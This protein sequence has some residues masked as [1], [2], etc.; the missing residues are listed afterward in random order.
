MAM[1]KSIVL[2][3]AL[4]GSPLA[5]AQTTAPN[6]TPPGVASSQLS[7]A[8]IQK[9]GRALRDVAQIKMDYS[10][11]MQTVQDPGQRQQL[12]QEAQ[13]RQIQAVKNEGL[14]LQ[15]YNQVMQTAQADPGVKQRVLAAAGAQ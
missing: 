11:R 5:M 14:S 7:N 4:V 8:T 12:A 13:G 1:W 10:Q 9:A 15:Q 2:A 6:G 3:A